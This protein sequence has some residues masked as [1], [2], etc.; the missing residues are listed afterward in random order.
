MKRSP[1]LTEQLR[2][3]KRQALHATRLQLH[4]PVTDQLMHWQSPLP[5][6]MQELLNALEDDQAHPR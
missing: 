6:D 5:S 3:F 4:H 1:T 2:A